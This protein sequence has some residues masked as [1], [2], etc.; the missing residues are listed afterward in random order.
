MSFESC[1]F[2]PVLN[3]SQDYGLF[4]W[5][6]SSHQVSKSTGASASVLPINEHRSTGISS[7][8]GF[9]IPE[10]VLRTG[11]AGLF[12]RSTVTFWQTAVMFSIATT[13]FLYIRTV[14]GGFQLFTSLQSLVFFCYLSN[15][16]PYTCDVT[17]HCGFELH[18]PDYWCWASFHV[19]V[20]HLYIFF[21]EMA[22]SVLC[23]FSDQVFSFCHW[24]LQV[25]YIL[26]MASLSEVEFAN[27]S[28]QC[29]GC[30][31]SLLI[32]SFAV[33]TFL[34]WCSASWLFLLFCSLCF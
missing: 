24:F 16:H 20:S 28:S 19:S 15:S 12:G 29:I 21:G 14:L 17:S 27:I 30:L 1:H 25:L 2:S 26:D 18:F 11:I 9:Y 33:Q 4:Q 13:S 3:L 32:L 23:L 34:V 22:I 5:V 10:Y 7:R 6:S 8:W 31:F